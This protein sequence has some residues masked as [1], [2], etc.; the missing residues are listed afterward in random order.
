[1]MPFVSLNL[2]LS[3]PAWGW[4]LVALAASGILMWPLSLVVASGIVY[5]STLR[6]ETP[7]KWGNGP[8]APN[9][10]LSM[11]MDGIGQEWLAAHETR[12]REVRIV[13]G[14]LELCGEY[15]DL[16]YDRAVMILSGRTESRRYGYFFSAPYEGAGYNVLVVDPRAHGMSG[17]EFNT[18]GFEESRDALAWARFLHDELGVSSVLYH[19]ICIGAAGA[20]LA[21][22]SEDCPDYVCGVVA[23]G[24]FPNF[25][26]SMKNHLIERKKPVKT[27][28]PFIDMWM[29]H[30]TGH[31]MSHGPL[32]VIHKLRVPLLMLH[33]KEDAYSLPVNAQ[34]L[35]ERA[36]SDEKR[37]V[38][39]EHGRHSMLR[40]TDP[41][42]YDGAIAAFVAENF[43]SDT[44]V[45]E[46]I[47]H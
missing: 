29:R 28:Y 40:I 2:F 47:L 8:S 23:E 1:M 39:F 46:E 10:P 16:G 27:F 44:A 20:I 21:A 11:K 18:V 3:V 31:S 14:G 45:S 41:A 7:E 26:E 36:G 15:F 12:K 25:G 37:L 38:W 35:Y 6:R 13:N 42:L 9:D 34:K 24:M 19:G 17:G 4:V 5:N 32:D 22:T 30:Y 43:S 33:S